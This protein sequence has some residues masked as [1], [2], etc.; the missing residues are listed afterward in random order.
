M[1][2]YFIYCIWIGYVEVDLV[3]TISNKYISFI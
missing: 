3:W 2:F 1:T